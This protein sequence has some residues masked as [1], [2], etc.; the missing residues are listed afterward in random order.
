[1]SILVFNGEVSHAIR[2]RPRSGDYR[3]QEAYGGT[4]ARA[5][6]TPA[7]ADLARA[8]LA[9]VGEPLLYARV[10]IVDVEGA[11]AIMELEL[12]E[13]FFYIDETEEARR[14]AAAVEARLAQP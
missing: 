4:H 7:E 5:L 13:P 2:K 6:P 14:F 8:A 9:A 3:V 11:P 1:L 12:I 10:D